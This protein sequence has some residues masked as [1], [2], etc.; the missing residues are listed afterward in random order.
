MGSVGAFL[1]LV[2]GTKCQ[3]IL[4][5]LFKIGPSELYGSAIL[6]Y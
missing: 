2:L 6:K 3:D 4:T 5:I 1:E